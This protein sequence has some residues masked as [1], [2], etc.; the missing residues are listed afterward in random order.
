MI[1]TALWS[2]DPGDEVLHLIWR[3]DW[4]KVPNGTVLHSIS[5]K[6]HI[7]GNK[8]PLK[9]DVRGGWMPL[10]FRKETILVGS[11]LS[12]IVHTN[13]YPDETPQES[14]Q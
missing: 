14:N 7:K 1:R 13:P 12:K 2:D 8:D 10:G 6:E 3:D 5:G 11:E 9:S 4:D